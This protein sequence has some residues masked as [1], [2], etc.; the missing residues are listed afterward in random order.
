MAQ[1][2]TPTTSSAAGAGPGPGGADD[3]VSLIDDDIVR[4]LVRV[5]VHV[6][7]YAPY[8]AAT[9]AF[10]VMLLVVPALGGGGSADAFAAGG[11]GSDPATPATPA[12]TAPRSST[13]PAEL[14]SSASDFFDP[15]ITTEATRSDSATYSFDEFDYRG[16][17]SDSPA[18]TESEGSDK[19]CAV[20]PPEGAPVSPI[21]PEKE[22]DNV[23]N[24]L[25]AVTGEEA[26]ADAGDTV[27]QGVEA[28][29]ECDDDAGAQ[30]IPDP[31]DAPVLPASTDLPAVDDDA[32][33]DLA[34][35]MF[36][37]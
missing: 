18:S 27:S 33:I 17:E 26:P 24:T 23:Q 36:V 35:A 21:V 12:A 20:E 32:V 25:E 10:G 13:A 37:I 6:R 34:G 31:A 28:I 3:P 9:F 29:G 2:D 22:A 11:S 14:A 16:S 8:Y 5:A 7:G 19:P 4:R 15:L 30:S 1:E